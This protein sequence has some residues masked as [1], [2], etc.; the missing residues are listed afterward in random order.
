MGLEDIVQSV[1][2]PV[3]KLA[4]KVASYMPAPI[5]KV[6]TAFAKDYNSLKE[7]LLK[8][9]LRPVDKAGRYMYDFST[10]YVFTPLNKLYQEYPYLTTIGSTFAFVY[11]FP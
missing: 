1:L 9:S 7:I 5:G 8:Y 11:F 2:A 4:A 3:E 10:K 6:C